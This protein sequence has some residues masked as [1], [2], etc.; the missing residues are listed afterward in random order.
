MSDWRESYQAAILET[1][2]ANLESRIEQAEAAIRTQL[3]LVNGAPD[4]AAQVK[5]M[6]TAAGRL[7]LLRVERL[8]EQ[9][10]RPQQPAA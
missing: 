4:R 2:D 10:G 7:T 6:W 9:P 3:A 1:D 5:E 8:G